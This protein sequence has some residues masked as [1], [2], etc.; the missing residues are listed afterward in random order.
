MIETIV[1]EPALKHSYIF[2]VDLPIVLQDLLHSESS[3]C[4]Y[5]SCVLYTVLLS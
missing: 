3:H 4:V 5:L 2:E 1:W